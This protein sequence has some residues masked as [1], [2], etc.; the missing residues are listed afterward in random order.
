MGAFVGHIRAFPLENRALVPAKVFDKTRTHFRGNPIILCTIGV[1]CTNVGC[2]ILS[3][4]NLILYTSNF[5]L[6]CILYAESYYF[7]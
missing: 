5:C 4:P 7:R 3:R 1:A 2:T 6:V